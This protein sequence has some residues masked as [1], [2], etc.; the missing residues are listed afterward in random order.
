MVCVTLG[1]QQSFCPID[2]FP[3]SKTKS[4]YIKTTIQALNKLINF[5]TNTVMHIQNT[6]L[7]PNI[8][9]NK[10]KNYSLILSG[11]ILLF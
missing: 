6:Y 4:G 10:P 11:K 7:Q 8:M 5:I 3:V 1:K 2:L 9:K